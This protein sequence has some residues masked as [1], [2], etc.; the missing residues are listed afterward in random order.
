MDLEV[1]SSVFLNKVFGENLFLGSSELKIIEKAIPQYELGHLDRV[2]KIEGLS[3]V[4]FTI[5]G[6]YMYGVSLIDI[7]SK[8][9]EVAK[10]CL[11]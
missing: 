2:L 3:P 5:L 10:E 11:T 8:S 6:N 9:K 4:A 7:I 1:E